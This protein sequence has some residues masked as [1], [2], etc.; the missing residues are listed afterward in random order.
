MA[1][2]N[3]MEKEI[4]E[5]CQAGD[6]DSF[7]Y[8]YNTY[9]EKVYQLA[10]RYFNSPDDA[11]DIVQETFIRI[12]KSISGYRGD[13]QFST[14]VYRIATN[15]CYDELRRRKK[16]QEDSFDA[17]IE[18]EKGS[19]AREIVDDGPSPHEKA[20]SAERIRYLMEKLSFLPKEQRAS[21]ILRD[22][23]GYSYQEIAE[24]QNCSLG[25]VK[26]RI[27]RGRCA[28]KEML[29]GEWEL[30]TGIIGQNEGRGDE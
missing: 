30:F 11:S 2:N 5:R 26:S 3:A 23:H 6:L 22:I 7:D 4:I 12:Y 29:S 18:T 17:D 28:I 21:V 13:A 24:I 10:Y 19:I 27:S 9:A 20:E 25:T 16:R 8:L 14:W 15:L 1:A